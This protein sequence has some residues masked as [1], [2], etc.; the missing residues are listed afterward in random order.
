MFRTT[1]KTLAVLERE[2]EVVLVEIHG[3][4]FRVGDW[5]TLRQPPEPPLMPP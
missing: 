5:L 3:G 1:L 4:A 2:M